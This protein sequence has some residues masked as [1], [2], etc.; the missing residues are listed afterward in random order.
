M[1]E[2]ESVGQKMKYFLT[3]AAF[4]ISCLC[5]AEDPADDRT[6]CVGG[7]PIEMQ[8]DAVA[9][10]VAMFREIKGRYPDGDSAAISKAI[11][12]LGL[13]QP[14]DR[15]IGADGSILDLWGTPLVIACS[16]SFGVIVLSGGPDRD[17]DSAG[18]CFKFRRPRKN[19]RPNPESCV[20]PERSGAVNTTGVEHARG[21]SET[22]PQ[23][24]KD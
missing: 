8:L 9:D 15:F 20:R 12:A 2:N 18:R 1:W 17:F 13:Y 3:L 21:G 16:E 24:P 19:E 6:I 23:P 14:G 22:K 11:G 7:R 5:F 10:S 4:V